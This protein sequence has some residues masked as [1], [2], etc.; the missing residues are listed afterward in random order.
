MPRARIQGSLESREE[1]GLPRRGS[2]F[3]PLRGPQRREATAEGGRT[4]ASY[5]P[6]MGGGDCWD[7]GDPEGCMRD[8]PCRIVDYMLLL[9]FFL[10]V[11]IISLYVDCR[12]YSCIC[13]SLLLLY[14]LCSIVLLYDHDV[15]CLDV[16]VVRVDCRQLVV[17]SVEIV[18]C[19][20]VVLLYVLWSFYC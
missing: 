2:C 8:C 11:L 5:M 13:C 6:R 10:Y 4:H 19:M 17:V 16:V 7:W 1:G 20:I 18:Y 15:V 14:V 9:I 3:P 12:L